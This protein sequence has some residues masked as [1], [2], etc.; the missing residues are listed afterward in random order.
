MNKAYKFRLYPNK[1]QREFFAKT[2]GCCRFIYNKMLEDKIKHYELTKKMLRNTPAM[3]KNRY[4]WLKEVDSLA[5]AN[6]Q[7]HLEKAYKNF[8]R[9][10]K[11]GFPKFKSKRNHH[12][13]YTTNNQRGTI[14][15]KDGFIKVPKLKSTIKIIQHREIGQSEQIKSATISQTPTGKYYVSILVNYHKEEKEVIEE[16]KEFDPSKVIGLDYSMKELYVNSRGEHAGYPRYYRQSL[17]QLKRAGRKL[18]LCKKGSN[19]Y[20]K[21]RLRVARLHEKIADQRKDFLHKQSRQITNDYE[22]VVVESLDLKAMSKTLK[23]GMSIADNGYGRFVEY[24]SYKL[25]DEGKV[26]VRV[27]KWYASSKICSCCGKKKEELP[28]SERV[29]SCECGNTINRDVNAGINI[30]NEGIRLLKAQ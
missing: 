20:N 13:S 9:D 30:K 23:L 27:D 6:V 28:L 2:F 4:E 18:S 5:L 24:L 1:E 17:K 21:Q 8:F 3:Y 15:I 14:H 25:R 7:L 26:L 19:N 11:V 12:Q 22:I 29:F 10:K 16:I